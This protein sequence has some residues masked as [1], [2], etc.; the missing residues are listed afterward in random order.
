MCEMR[1]INTN[2]GP[3]I[4]QLTPRH[5]SSEQ[6]CY[7]RLTLFI[8]KQR[9]PCRVVVHLIV[10][11]SMI[12]SDSF[13]WGMPRFILEEVPLRMSAEPLFPT[14]VTLLQMKTANQYEQNAPGIFGWN[15]APANVAVTLERATNFFGSFSLPQQQILHELL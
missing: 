3:K 5:H 4:I 1:W 12:C 6:V 2:R 10:N 7:F 11:S 15:K 9:R 14:V 8:M 13:C